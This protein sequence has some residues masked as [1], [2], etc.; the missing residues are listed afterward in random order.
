MSNSELTDLVRPLLLAGMK[1]FVTLGIKPNPTVG[2]FGVLIESQERKSRLPINLGNGEKLFPTGLKVDGDQ[3]LLSYF[4][5]K[6]D[7]NAMQQLNQ[8]I[9][10]RDLYL[11]INSVLTHRWSGIYALGLGAF[12]PQNESL[13]E[14]LFREHSLGDDD[15]NH[16]VLSLWLNLIAQKSSILW[17]GIP[18]SFI[19]RD[20]LPGTTTLNPSKQL[21]RVFASNQQ[22]KIFKKYWLPVLTENLLIKKAKR[23]FLNANTV[24]INIDLTWIQCQTCRLIEASKKIPTRCFACESSSLKIVDVLKDDVFR[25]R[26]SYYR[27]S[28]ERA[29][30]DPEFSPI[31]IVS[32]EH[33]AQIN[34]RSDTDEVFS[35]SERYELLFQDVDI[36]LNTKS[37]TTA[38]DFLSCTTTMEVG[39]DIGALSGVALRNMPPNRAAYQQRS[40]RAGRR[41]SA[42]A[43]VISYASTESHDRYY[44]DNPEELIRG[45]AKDP[46]LNLDNLAIVKRHITVYLLQKY[47]RD[48]RITGEMESNMLASLGDAMTFYEGMSLPNEKKYGLEDF[49]Q[50]T[51]TNEELLRDDIVSWLPQQIKPIQIES[52]TSDFSWVGHVLREAILKSSAI[53]QDD[54]LIEST[55]SASSNENEQQP[56]EIIEDVQEITDTARKRHKKTVLLMEALLD[57]GA[58]PKNA[59]PIDVATFTIFD[60]E[61]STKYRHVPLYAPQQ[62]MNLALTQYAP[63]RSVTI[64]N[65]TWRSEAIYSPFDKERTDEWFDRSQ[66]FYEC[67]RCG[68]VVMDIFDQSLKND[69][70]DC[71]VCSGVQTLGATTQ[72]AKRWIRPNGFA[73][74]LD[75][76]EKSTSDETSR[77]SR[78]QLNN[79]TYPD[80]LWRPIYPGIK[81]FSQRDNLIVTNK[82]PGSKGFD[83]CVSCGRIRPSE[84][85]EK[86]GNTHRIP[87]PTDFQNRDCSSS[88]ISTGVLLGTTF[89]SD[90]LLVRLAVSKPVEILPGTPV[91][92]SAIRTM[93]EALTIAGTQLLELDSNEISGNFRAAFSVDEDLS[94]QIEIFLYDTTPGGAAYTSAIFDLGVNLFERAHAVLT[95]CNSNCDSACYDCLMSYTNRFDHG[96]LDRFLAADLL[97]HCMTGT[98]PKL[99]QQKFQR[100]LNSLLASLKD[101]E[102]GSRIRPNSLLDGMISE[103]YVPLMIESGAKT[104][105]FD[106]AHPLTPGIFNS[107]SLQQ[108]ADEF[109]PDPGTVLHA[110]IDVLRISE[111]L[112]GV[113]AE[114]IEKT[115]E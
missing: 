81:T 114:I 22:A 76:K 50:W 111:D 106:L 17:S 67:N 69:K 94:N 62:S 41:G 86:L 27:E 55:E 23:Y 46:F 34:T 51:A 8:H 110:P 113:V 33:T 5:P 25:S 61:A 83:Y 73:H 16:R 3:P 12:A 30:T 109:I 15:L 95:D 82:G 68:H 36:K 87:F 112:P 1:R 100:S 59:F 14:E 91:T 60:E 7:F 38:I 93:T 88:R 49:I 52:L 101:T 74:P 84:T 70:R 71:E 21:S 42:L 79:R 11:A 92:E 45:D 39:I 77:A 80:N 9:F 20:G 103:M 89:E 40:G 29:M 43:T 18:D 58:I 54:S 66:I 10:P 107:H 35:R 98:I 19:G 97:E 78:A 37:N 75:L 44:F 72:G 115:K 90:V 2:L 13:I 47:H 105:L 31:S 24:V 26:R 4:V 28:S 104:H 102:L 99:S 108:M 32:R 56:E 48:G 57:G 64:D 96:V 85:H 53:P 6:P 65:K 63:G